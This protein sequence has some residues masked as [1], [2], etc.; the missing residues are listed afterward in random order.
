MLF[1]PHTMTKKHFSTLLLALLAGTLC[2]AAQQGKQYPLV[3]EGSQCVV[4]GFTPY[5][6]LNDEKIFAHTLLWAIENVC[7]QM[8]DGIEDLDVTTKSFSC[9]LTLA[10]DGQQ[11]GKGNEYNCKAIF[12]VADGK[13]VYHLSNIQMQSTVLVMKKVTPIEKL[14]PEKKPAHKEAVDEFVKLESQTLNKLF[15]YVSSYRSSPITHWENIGN[16]I[17]VK[18]MT[19]DECRLAFGKPQ[20]IQE[21]NGETQWSYGYS[22]YLFF[23]NGRVETIIK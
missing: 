10:P 17:P 13:L 7:P 16:A 1:I 14:N 19:P 2:V 22:F 6:N 23:K 21:S 15:D 20:T 12:R 18:G 4:G 8:R 11:P 9:N 5:N 3:K